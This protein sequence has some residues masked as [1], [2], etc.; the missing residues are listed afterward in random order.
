MQKK[1]D[2]Q[3]LVNDLTYDDPGGTCY[4][5]ERPENYSEIEEARR[6]LCET[7]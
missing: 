6:I 4:T 3:Y 1:C 5:L 7:V 2:F